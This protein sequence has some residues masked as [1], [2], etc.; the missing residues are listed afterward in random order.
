MFSHND[1][2]GLLA[3]K[4]TKQEDVLYNS[5]NTRF[6]LV[7]GRQGETTSMVTPPLCAF[8]ISKGTQ[9]WNKGEDIPSF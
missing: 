4:Q 3:Y 1:H 5:D 2:F 9:N 7:F 6:W 8:E